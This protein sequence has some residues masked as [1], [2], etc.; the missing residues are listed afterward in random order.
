MAPIPAHLYGRVGVLRCMRINPARDIAMPALPYRIT[1]ADPTDPG[2]AALLA[3]SHALMKSLYAPEENFQ[4]DPEALRGPDIRFFAVFD[5]ATCLGIGALAI[6][7]GY[8]EVKSLFVAEAARGR[9]VAEALLQHIESAAR[10]HRL[11]ALKLETGAG[12]DAALRLYTRQG[13]VPCGP[14]GAYP[15]AP[16]SVFLEK[17]L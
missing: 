7:E 8:G 12:L 1:R 4:L 9:G 3:Q 15:D 10:S 13:F 2:P 14:F 5:E 16:K 6:R 17:R 11:T